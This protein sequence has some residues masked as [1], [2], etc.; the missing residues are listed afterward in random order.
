MDAAKSIPDIGEIEPPVAQL[1]TI[2][3]E[4]LRNGNT[5]ESKKLFDACCRDGIFYLDMLGTEPDVLQ[6]VEDVYVLEQSIFG[7]AEEDLMQYDIDKLSPRKL[8]G[9]AAPKVSEE[10]DHG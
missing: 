5:A 1:E 8:N 4:T 6:A 7:E 2:C 3:F 10:V 9:F